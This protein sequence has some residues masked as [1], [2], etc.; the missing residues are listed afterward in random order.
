[1]SRDDSPVTLGVERPQSYNR[2]TVLLR[3]FVIAPHAIVF[4]FLGGVQLIVTLLAWGAI[5][6]TGRY[7]EGLYT[8]SLGIFRWCVRLLAYVNLLSD[9]YPPL[10][11]E[12]ESNRPQRAELEP[13]RD[14]TT[15]RTA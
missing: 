10:S 9:D 4:F 2:L 15:S 11:P 14:M 12:E 3:M 7:P 8:A 13:A 6:A 5:L 1:M